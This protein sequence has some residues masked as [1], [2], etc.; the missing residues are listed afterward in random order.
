[1]VQR[2]RKP[3]D[4]TVEQAQAIVDGRFITVAEPRVP[5]LRRLT[6]AMNAMVGRLKLMFEAQAA[7]VESLRTQAYMD[8]VSGVSNRKHFI[9]R[10]NAAR[11]SDYADPTAGLVLLRLLE[12]AELNRQ[13]GHAS[14]DRLIHAISQALQ[15]YSDRVQGCHVGRLN[16]SDFALYLPVGGQA[17]E[18]ANA[19]AESMRKILPLFG[20]HVAVALGAVEIVEN[21]PLGDVLA[22]ADDAL[23]RAESRGAFT[24]ELA[25]QQLDAE[26]RGAPLGEGAWRE[27]LLS[28]LDQRRAQLVRFPVVDSARQSIHLEC[29]LRLQL[30]LEGRFETAAYWLPLA[31]RT[32]L[33]AAIDE[34]AVRLALDQIAASDLALCVNLSPASLSDSAFAARLRGV[35]AERPALA[36]RLSLEVHE[37][38]AVEQFELVQELSRQL[39]PLGVRFGLEHA[40]QRLNQVD[41]LFEAGLDYVKL[42]AAVIHGIDSDTARAGF[43][44]GLVLM[45]H[46]LS[47]Q[48]IAEGVATQAEADAAWQAGVDGQTGPWVSAI[49]A[50]LVG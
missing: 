21:R 7:Q 38:A 46:G 15:S 6:Q 8:P 39:R 17:H 28:A 24:V 47:L 22:A 5:E 40:G 2:I 10:L 36:R 37:S 35:L 14:T 30:E 9:S 33:T 12:L 29:P 48:V 25:D 42:D 19:V 49:R 16:G 13:L 11:Q 44:R 43:L 23:A 34:L 27:N 4:S 41:R 18:T 20:S 3:L 32:R 1:M 31:L 45:L 50:D 26:G